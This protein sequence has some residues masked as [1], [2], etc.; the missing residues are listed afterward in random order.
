MVSDPEGLTPPP[1][2][3]RLDDQAPDASSLS[4]ARSAADADGRVLGGQHG[5]GAARHRPDLAVHADDAQ[6]GAGGGR[7][8][9]GLWRGDTQALGA[10]QA[11]A[12]RH[13]HAGGVGNVGLQRALL[14][15]RPL[16][17]RH[18]HGHPARRVADLRAGGRLP[19]ARH[20]RRSGAA[21]RR[22]DHRRRRGRGRHPRRAAGDPRGRVQQGRSRHAGGV[23]AL[24]LLHGGAARPPA[25]AGRRLLHAAGADR[26]SDIAAAGGASRRSRQG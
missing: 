24:R 18:Q 21:C 11:A 5:G 3:L 22:A 14:C 25:H 7:A 16:H 12:L 10:D 17:E 4:V 19:R 20:P 8:V 23:R 2:T 13:R 9:A 15:R 1:R 26:G 6:V